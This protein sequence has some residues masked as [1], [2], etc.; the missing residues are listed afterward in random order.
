MKQIPVINKLLLMIFMLC[1]LTNYAQKN[2]IKI[3]IPMKKGKINYE[4]DYTANKGLIKAELYNRATK[5][6]LK[7][8]PGQQKGST[9]NKETGMVSGTGIFKVITSASGNYYWLRFNVDITVSDTGYTFRAYNYYEK[10]IETG[11]TND[12]S[13]IEYRWWDYRRGHPW[14]VED[15]RLFIGLNTSSL[16]LLASFKADLGK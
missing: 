2:T 16:Q 9:F 11:I 7:T 10:P 5:W 3:D 6:F 14:S 12:Y 15:T 8:F 1:P 13:K 4:A